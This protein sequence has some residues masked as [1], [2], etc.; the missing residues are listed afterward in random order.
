MPNVLVARRLELNGPL[1]IISSNVLGALTSK[2]VSL[3]WP[4]I[5]S[6]KCGVAVRQNIVPLALSVVTP[7]VRVRQASLLRKLFRMQ[8]T[9]PVS[10]VYKV[11]L[12]SRL[13]PLIPSVVLAWTKLLSPRVK[14]L[15]STV[16]R[17]M[18]TTCNL[19]LSRLLWSRPHSVGT[20]KCPIRLLRVL[21]RNSAAGGVGLVPDP[22]WTAR[23]T[24]LEL[25]YGC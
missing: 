17:L 14:V 15:L 12:S 19:L 1:T 24:P 20:S 7:V 10:P 11:G 8:S 6:K 21:N 13:F 3:R 23:A 25:L 18:L 22:P 4:I 9:F 2:L 16:P 5:L